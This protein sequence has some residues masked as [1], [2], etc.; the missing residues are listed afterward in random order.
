MGKGVV[1]FSTYSNAITLSSIFCALDGYP[2]P[3]FLPGFK[4][5]EQG[6]RGNW[7]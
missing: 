4:Q 3:N 1:F 6:G 5:K 7:T 2:L